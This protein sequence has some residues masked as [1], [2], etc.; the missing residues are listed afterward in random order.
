MPSHRGPWHARRTGRRC[1]AGGGQRTPVR[2]PDIASA[3]VNSPAD[4]AIDSLP[5][6]CTRTH[7]RGH[8]MRSLP[9]PPQE[10]SVIPRI[11]A[12][13][14]LGRRLLLGRR[15]QGDGRIRHADA[16]ILPDDR[17]ADGPARRAAFWIEL[18]ED[19]WGLGV[20]RFPCRQ[21]V[22]HRDGVGPSPPVDVVVAGPAEV[23]GRGVED[24]ADVGGGEVRP[25]GPDEGAERGD[26]RRRGGRPAEGTIRW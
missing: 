2:L 24:A 16:G 22:V 4:E 21:L 15:R 11:P 12:D 23:D 5:H 8:K 10:R 6:L 7:Q 20:R 13:E 3:A 19:R 25:G 17:S 9:P 1:Q 26:V 14:S 18:S